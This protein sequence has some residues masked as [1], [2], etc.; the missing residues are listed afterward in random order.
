MMSKFLPVLVLFLIFQLPSLSQDTS[1]PFQQIP[2]KPYLATPQL[3]IDSEEYNTL[4]LNM[5]AKKSGTARLFWANHYDPQFNQP[6]S[7][8]FSVK[9]GDHSYVFNLASQNPNWVG[10]TKGFLIYPETKVKIKQA[11]VIKGN[12]ITNIKSGWLEFWG[13]RGRLVVGSTINT[14]QSPNLYGKPIFIYIYWLIG[15]MIVGIIIFEIKNY[16]TIKEKPPINILFTNIG[17]KIFI[18]T[19]ICWFF[20]EAS[21]LSNNWQQAKK[22][23]RLF[24]KS[25]NEK[26]ALVN[27]GD[28]FPFIQFCKMQL[29]KQAKFDFR[30]GGMYNDIKAKYYLYPR[31]Y[32]KNSQ[33]MLI[34][35]HKMEPELLKDYKLWKNFR[36]GALILKRK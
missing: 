25:L 4:V 31:E 22:D 15:L 33:F 28:F 13:P 6:K 24:G 20:L 1:I 23:L 26:R 21:A 5:E 29:P 11:K 9:A 30:I 10:W 35:D 36:P 34:Y 18:A 16:F 19:I 27:T 3:M 2:G 8:W 7:I 17:K 32:R 12:L 14:I